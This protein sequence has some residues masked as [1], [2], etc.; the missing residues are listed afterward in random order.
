MCGIN[1]IFIKDQASKYLSELQRMNKVLRH[2]GPDDE[3][4]YQDQDILLGHRRLSIIDLSKNATQPMSNEDQTVWIVFNGE[5]YNFQSLR[6]GLLNKGHIF[7]SRS[8]TEVLIHGYEEW[9]TSLLSKLDGMFAFGLWDK[10]QRTLLLGRDG[11]GIKPLFYFFDGHKLIF[12]SEIKGVLAT[13]L[14]ERK[15][16]LQSLSNYLSLFYVPNPDTI[17]DNIKQVVPG[18]YILFSRDNAPQYAKFWDVKDIAENKIWVTSE[19]Q[20]YEQVRE[21]ASL[22]VKNAL[23]A[24]VPISLLFSAGLDSSIILR[25]LK[26]LGKFDIDTVTIGFTE[27]S[28]DESK[29]A[30]RLAA[31]LG[32]QNT[33]YIMQESNVPHMLENMIYHLDALNAN[34]CIFTDYFSFEKAAEKGKV[35]MT[36]TGNDEMLAGYSTYIADEYCRYYGLL[37]FFV[38]KA[39]AILARYLPVSEKKYSFDYLAQKFTEGSLFHKEKSHYWWRTI[40]SD[41]EKQALFNDDFLQ[42]N[43]IILDSFCTHKTYYDRVKDILSFHEQSLY[44]D[45]YLFLIDN[46]NMK[47]DQLS[48]AFSVES[49]PPF[50]TKRFVEFA[51]SLPYTFKLHGKQ[52]KYCLRRAYNNILPDYIVKRKKQGSIAPLGFLFRKEMK[53]FLWDSLLSDSLSE[54]FDLE[55]IEYL[56]SK[57][58]KGLQ[59]NSYK[60][61]ALLVFAIWKKHF[62][63]C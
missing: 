52:T 5:I 3:G 50:L 45:F 54:F 42:D 10:K 2:R 37:P 46:A 43:A 38:R 19:E 6:H 32:F 16:H 29:L 59:N 21:E 39:G 40:F 20:I 4:I 33:V 41:E 26:D 17:I 63:D 15:I 27:K 49:R 60:L 53:S 23:I 34:P 25:E 30:K 28:F 47:V 11:C 18:S 7:H 14:I 61:F 57:Q 1:G 24:D 13:G 22:A 9:G 48:M 35:T 58:I 36:G 44:T 31:E 8:D 55:Y 51:F 56:L 12:S 62:I